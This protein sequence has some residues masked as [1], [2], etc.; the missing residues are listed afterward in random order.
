MDL[1]ETNG[2]DTTYVGANTPIDD[3]LVQIKDND[4]NVVAISITM[5]SN[6][7]N[8][9]TTINMIRSLQK[10][11]L[12]ILVGGYPFNRNESLWKMVGADGFAKDFETALNI[13]NAYV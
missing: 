1:F 4:Y 3:L 11:N 2:W 10:P 6:I 7:N 12:K 8:V 5:V 9:I 13:A